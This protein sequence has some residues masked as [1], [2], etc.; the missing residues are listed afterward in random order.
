MF[1]F[2]NEENLFRMR[3][4][5]TRKILTKKVIVEHLMPLFLLVNLLKFFKL[6]FLFLTLNM[7]LPIGQFQSGVRTV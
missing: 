3:N 7:Q 1:V 6:L 2:G 5:D 4:R